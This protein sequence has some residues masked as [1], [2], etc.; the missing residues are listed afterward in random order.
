MM[1]IDLF[2]GFR[3]CIVLLPPALLVVTGLALAAL[4]AFAAPGYFRFPAVHGET[5][6]FTAEGDLWTTSAAG[7]EAR[8]LTT[9]T[10]QE[11]QSALSPDGTRVAFVGQYEGPADVYVMPL[12]GGMPTRLSF[13]GGRVDVHGW[14][15]QG[16]VVYSSEELSGPTAQRV[17]RLVNPSTLATRE[18]PLHDAQ[19]VAFD[20]KGRVLFTRFGA[21]VNGDNARGYR[22]GAMGQLWLFDPATDAEARRLG[23][24]A[25]GAMSNPMRL[26]ERWYF[27]GNRDGH[28]ALWSM[29]EDGG[30][31]RS[32]A[33]HAPWDVRSARTDGQRIAYQVGADVHL[34]SPQDNSHRAVDLSLLSDFERQRERWLE[35]PLRF[36]ESSRLAPSGDRVALT[37]RGRIALAAPG[38]LRRVEVATPANQRARGAVLSADGR[39]VYAIADHQGRQEIWRFAADGRAEAK[40]LTSDGSTHRWAL[41]PS[42]DGRYL[43]HTDKGGALHLLDLNSGRNTTIDR[44]TFGDDGFEDLVWSATAALWPTFVP[45]AARRALRC[46]CSASGCTP[47]RGDQRPLRLV[48]PAFS[49]DGRWLYFLSDRSFVASPSGPWGDRN[50]GPG[51]DRR[52]KVYALALQPGNRFPF[53]APNELAAPTD[54]AADAP[55]TDKAKAEGIAALPAIVIDGLAERLFEAPVPPGNYGS[56]LVDAE[57]F[58]LLD[59]A[60]VP[61]DGGVLKTF[62]IA[63]QGSTLEDFASGVRSAQISSDGKRIALVQQRDSDDP[64]LRIVDAGAKP[65]TDLGPSTVRLGD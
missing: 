4:P 62:G 55:D 7:G 46:C 16:E 57:R 58:Y 17:L 60:P 34:F 23:S 61:S 59:R 41:Y 64:T 19:Q 45:T 10:G 49:P 32:H 24:D 30:D 1:R 14:S 21:H 13:D 44:D 11:T 22:G 43:A 40:P 15:P 6:V 38:P 29:N 63:A 50:T 2:L 36:L 37:V 33:N 28:D 54:K 25:D 18:L 12:S 5:L 56:L 42:P 31:W 51:F 65:P 27:I 48:S 47:E 26:G 35:R 52:S 3:R 8:R 9:H 39:W 20:A 53:A